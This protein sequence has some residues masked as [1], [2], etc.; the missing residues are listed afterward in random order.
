MD[1]NKELEVVTSAFFLEANINLLQKN[2][3]ELQSQMPKKPEEPK[4]IEVTLGTPKYPTINT[5]SVEYPKHWKL[6]SLLG[7]AIV[8]LGFLV[9]FGGSDALFM[10]GTMIMWP[11]GI[12]LAIYSFIRGNREKKRL[13]EEYIERVK[14]SQEYINKCRQID[15]ERRIEYEKLK[16]DT[17]NIY[18]LNLEK[19]NTSLKDYNENLLPQW[20]E[21]YKALE[22]ALSDTNATLRELYG[23]NI[24]PGECRNLNAVS[25]LAAYLSTSQFDLGYAIERYNDK[26]RDALLKENNDLQRAQILIMTE[27]RQNQEYANYLNEQYL[28]L[29][30]ASNET[31][32]SISNW[33]K[34]D[35]AMRTYERIKERRNAKR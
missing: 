21:E 19:Y 35:I 4:L 22:I 24:I 33:Q 17:Q 14:N 27:I 3:Q 5:T 9:M 25:Y 31:L 10:L 2:K 7:L 6:V 20:E 34:A 12:A 28:Y 8:I 16:E 23:T 18:A 26:K 30:E 15:E 29:T 1:R 32:R 11:G 13:T